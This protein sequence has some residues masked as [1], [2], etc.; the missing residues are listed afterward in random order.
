MKSGEELY[1]KKF[2]SFTA[3]QRVVLKANFN[4][5]RQAL[6]APTRESLSIIVTSTV[7][8]TGK[9]VAVK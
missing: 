9:P 6:Q 8:R 4:Y 1:S 2:Q 3:P 7:E 5:E